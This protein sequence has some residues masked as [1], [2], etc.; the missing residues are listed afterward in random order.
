MLKNSV[1]EGVRNERLFSVH[2]YYISNYFILFYDNNVL[3]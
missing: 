2:Y 1:S 3:L